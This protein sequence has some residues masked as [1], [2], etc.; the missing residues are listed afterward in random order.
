MFDEII[1]KAWNVYKAESKRSFSQRMRRLT[2]YAG[3]LNPGKLKTALLKFCSKKTWFI[4]SYDYANAHRTGNMI[5]RL[6]NRTD[7][8]LHVSKGWHGTMASA[9]IGIRG[10]CLVQ[11]FCPYCPSVQKKYDGKQSAF[12]KLNGYKY[13]ENWLENLIIATSTQ[14][15]YRFQQKTVE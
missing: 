2:E 10:F 15:K 6:I 7:R 13:S 12:E 5:D 9:E 1:D 8:K 14:Q 3:G 4:S 11:N